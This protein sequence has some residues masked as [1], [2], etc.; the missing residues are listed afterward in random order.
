MDRFD[1]DSNSIK[2][3]L[4][5]REGSSPNVSV[6][7][8]C[9]LSQQVPQLF[10]VN[11]TFSMWCRL[12]EASLCARH[13]RSHWKG[14]RTEGAMRAMSI[15]FEGGAEHLFDSCGCD[16]SRLAFL[17]IFPDSLRLKQPFLYFTSGF[18][19]FPP[20]TRFLHQFDISF[21]GTAYTETRQPSHHKSHSRLTSMADTYGMNGHNGHV[22]DRR[23]SSMNGRNRLY[24][25]QEPQRTTHLSE[26][27]KHMVAASGEFVGTFLFLYFGYAGNIVAVLQEPISGPNGTLANNTVMYIAMAYGF[28][29]LVNVWTFYR[30]SGGLFNPAVS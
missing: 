14:Q 30:I 18:P 9:G 1:V 25:Q 27:G 16:G 29:L 4:P 11:V 8:V 3:C 15:Y 19:C 28:S 26:F 6:E 23:S 7:F 13:T 21:L 5:S 12:T 22:K 10:T 2:T 17:L 24:A 20:P